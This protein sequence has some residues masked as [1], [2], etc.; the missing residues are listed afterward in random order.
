MD[1]KKVLKIGLEL[2]KLI[3]N[4]ANKKYSKEWMQSLSDDEL[5]TE[6]EKVRKFLCSAKKTPSEAVWA[7]SMLRQFD[8]EM[9]DRAW[10]GKDETEYEYPKHTKHGWYLSDDD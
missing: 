1:V 2:F 10:N 9:S 7:E 3:N 8:K 6:R 4:K 5:E